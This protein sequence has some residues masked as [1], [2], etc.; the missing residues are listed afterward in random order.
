MKALLKL[1]LFIFIFFAVT[2]IYAIWWAFFNMP[3]DFSYTVIYLFQF[4][5]ECFVIICFFQH[6]RLTR[7][8]IPLYLLPSSLI[9][10]SGQIIFPIM[11]LSSFYP[12]YMQILQ[13]LNSLNIKT[14]MIYYFFVLGWIIFCW[15][16]SYFIF[17]K[18]WGK[19]Q[20]D[21]SS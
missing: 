1:N 6:S 2:S 4:L 3:N 13:F 8:L 18:D 12:L 7:V 9:W 16:D 14:P 21:L 10:G 19:T 15:A 20:A 17:K 5:Y 11:S